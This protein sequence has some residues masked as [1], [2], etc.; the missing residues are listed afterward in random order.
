MA[1]LGRARSFQ[2]VLRESILLE[3][4][5]ECITSPYNTQATYVLVEILGKWANARLGIC[6]DTSSTN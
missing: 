1:Q 5:V 6:I 3:S 4:R 2:P